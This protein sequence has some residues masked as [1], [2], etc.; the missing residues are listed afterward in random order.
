MTNLIIEEINRDYNTVREL[1]E[2]IAKI[3]KTFW[4]VQMSRHPYQKEILQL[5]NFKIEENCKL[6][7]EISTSHPA[8]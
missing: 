6:I 1:R 3:K 7:K 2:Q 5:A 8:Q 4:A